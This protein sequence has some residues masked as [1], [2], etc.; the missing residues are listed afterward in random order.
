MAE[1]YVDNGNGTVT[2]QIA[3]GS[4]GA[5][6]T[7]NQ[8]VATVDPVA[9]TTAS[10]KQEVLDPQTGLETDPGGPPRGTAFGA[11]ASATFHDLEVQPGAGANGGDVVAF[12]LTIRNDSPATS[13]IHLTAFN[14][15]SKRRGLADISP[16]DGTSQDR[17]DIR[18]DADLRDCNGPDDGVC[19][20]QALG[21]GHFP[22][23]I[24]NGLLFAQMVWP[25]ANAHRSGQPVDGDQVF[26]DPSK[27]IAPTNFWL[28]SVKKNAPFPP[29]VRQAENFI[30]VKSGLFSGD[31]D[32]DALCAGEPAILKNP[33]QAPVKSNIK[34]RLGLPPQ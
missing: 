25:T 29:I 2:R 1:F 10:F 34:T 4:Y 21:I 24:G 14:I 16:L 26:V 3:A 22:N 28:E 18:L 17:R 31:P 12:N 23:V 32:A 33:N 30:C 8:Y 6:G 19:W 13:G 5:L 20:N 9:V 7:P 27:G 15:Q 11:L